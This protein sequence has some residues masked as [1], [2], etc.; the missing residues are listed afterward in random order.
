MPD[1][2]QLVI[3]SI[4]EHQYAL[5]LCDIERIVRMVE[6]TPLPKAPEIVMGV[7]NV[8]GRIIPAVNIRSR[9]GLP[10][11][12]IDMNDQLI[13]AHGSKLWIALLVDRVSGVMAYQDYEVTKVADIFPGIEYVKGIIKKENS[14]ILILDIDIILSSHEITSMD[15]A[16]LKITEGMT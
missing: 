6:I 9:F 11:R 4:D 1:L 13:I 3:L 8:Q 5:Q 14:L 16:I 15:D 2:N 10:L 7:I 12:E